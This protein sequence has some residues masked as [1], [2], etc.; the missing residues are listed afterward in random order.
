MHTAYIS[1][2]GDY[3][4]GKA[5]IVVSLALVLFI[6]DHL[7]WVWSWRVAVAMLAYTNVLWWLRESI[8]FTSL[9]TN[10]ASDS[11]MACIHVYDFTCVLC[12]N[13]QT[14]LKSLLAFMH[15]DVK[16]AFSQSPQLYTNMAIATQTYPESHLH[17]RS[18]KWSIGCPNNYPYYRAQIFR[19]GSI[20]SGV[21][22]HGTLHSWSVVKS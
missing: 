4:K 16:N 18:C 22:E 8:F 5:A 9:C 19:F 3:W 13:M 6:I 15:S 21:R 10:A 14:L 11:D 17:I 12:Y 20:V 7:Q 1:Q 2:L